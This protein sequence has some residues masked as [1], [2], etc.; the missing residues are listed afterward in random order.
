[1]LKV[2]DVV[3]HEKKIFEGPAVIAKI[4]GAR[5]NGE[6]STPCMHGE[7]HWV[8]PLDPSSKA[9]ETFE[10]FIGCTARILE[11]A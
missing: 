11:R 8:I 1:V 10:W 6:I 2:G 9:C 4:G 5:L 3:Y 7:W